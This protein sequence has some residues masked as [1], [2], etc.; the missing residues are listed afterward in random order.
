MRISMESCAMHWPG[1][2]TWSGAIPLPEGMK[3]HMRNLSELPRKLAICLCVLAAFWAVAH[4][5]GLARSQ[6][7]AEMRKLAASLWPAARKSG[8]SRKVF[9]AAFAGLTSDPEVLEKARNQAEF[10]MPL[11]EYLA[12]RVSEKRIA[13]GRAMKATHAARLAAIEKRY[14][15]D[16][17]IVLAIWGLESNYGEKKGDFGVVRA[18]ATL[19][20][21]RSRSRFGRSQL[22]AAL[23]ILQRGDVPADQFMGSWA[24]A[25]GHTQFIP[26]TFNAYAVDWTGDGKRDIWNSVSDALASTANYLSKSG[27][28]RG[29]PWGWRVALPKGFNHRLVGGRRTVEQWEKLGVEP[30]GDARTAP[31]GTAVTLIMP[32]SRKGPAYLVTRNFRAILAYNNA[33]SYA[34]SVGLLADRVRSG[35]ADL[36]DDSE[37]ELAKLEAQPSTE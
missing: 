26:T 22:I 31:A 27:W 35:T 33:A 34:L 11:A 23:R 17:N 30:V 9:D 37:N 10:K 21:T 20:N 15:V 1:N 36:A 29:L 28:K 2:S 18:L 14:G 5:P 3:L 24:G 25:M 8:V 7:S 13:N 4:E 6:P 32:A 12:S 19:A 16:R